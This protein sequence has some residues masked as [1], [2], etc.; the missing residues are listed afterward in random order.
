MQS[1][2]YS[3]G[4][5]ESERAVSLLKTLGHDIHE[6]KVGDDFTQTEFEMEFG[7]DAKYPMITVGMFR[8]TLKETLQ[9]MSNKGMLTRS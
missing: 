2:I 1:V 8:G 3:N 5:Q 4:N 9:Y 6:Y 7:G